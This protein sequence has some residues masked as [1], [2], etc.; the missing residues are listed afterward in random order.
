MVMLKKQKGIARPLSAS[1][2][3][4]PQQVSEQ[5]VR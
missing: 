1:R 2:K 3:K 4:D 5:L